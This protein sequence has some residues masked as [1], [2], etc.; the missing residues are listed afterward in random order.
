MYI[1]ST[2]YMTKKHTCIRSI[3]H[4]LREAIRAVFV[5]AKSLVRRLKRSRVDGEAGTSEWKSAEGKAMDEYRRMLENTF[6]SSERIDYVMFYI[7][8]WTHS[9]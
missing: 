9:T 8:N 6:G 1:Y 7:R 2:A 3:V 5:G 4:P